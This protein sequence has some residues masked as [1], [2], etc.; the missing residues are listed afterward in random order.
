VLA[1]AL[2]TISLLRFKG[3]VCVPKDAAIRMRTRGAVHLIMVTPG[4]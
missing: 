3:C 1:L 2:D 4:A